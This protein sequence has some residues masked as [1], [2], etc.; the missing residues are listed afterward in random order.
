MAKK[1]KKNQKRNQR[2]SRASKKKLIREKGG[3]G[4]R[5]GTC[6]VGPS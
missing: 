4:G 3:V 5:R 6:S 2:D 1:K